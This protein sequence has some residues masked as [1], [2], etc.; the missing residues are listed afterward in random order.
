ML[1]SILHSGLCLAIIVGVF[2]SIGP[3]PFPAL[4]WISVP[5]PTTIFAN[6]TGFSIE[7]KKPV[8]WKERVSD[9]LINFFLDSQLLL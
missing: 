3:F 7:N 2:W 4:L 1:Y 8:L 9:C 6:R 5:K